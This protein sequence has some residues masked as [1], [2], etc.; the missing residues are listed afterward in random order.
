MPQIFETPTRQELQVKAPI[1]LDDERVLTPGALRFLTNLHRE[2]GLRRLEILK[3]RIK[4]Q[5][6]LDDGKL[7]EFLPETSDIRTQN[8]KISPLPEALQDRRVEITGP[9][10]RKMIINALNSGAKVFMADFEDSTSPTWRN[11]IEGHA[12]LM[13]A[14]R[15][16]ISYQSGDKLYLVN[17][18]PASIHVR[19][20]GWHLEEKH[21]EVDGES[22]SASLV[23]FGLFAY[24]NAEL[25]AAKQ[26]GPF[27]YLPKLE[28]HQE[29]RLWNDVFFFT[30][31]SLEINRGTIKATVLIETIPAV[32]EMD[33]IIFEL[34][35]HMAGLNAGRWDY[36]FSVIKKLKKNSTALTPDRANITMAV[37]FM[38]AYAQLLVKTCHRRGAHA[39]G[40]MS[41]FIPSKDET[42]NKEAFE[43][44]T[45]DKARE[46]SYGYDGTWVAHPKLVSIAQAEFDKVLGKNPHQKNILRPDVNVSAHDLLDIASAG[47][48]ITEKGVRTNINIAIL[49]IESWLRG[50]G[51]VALYNLM[52]DAATAEISRAQ[53]WQWLNHENV[54]LS[55]GRAFDRD[56]YQQLEKEEMDAL[57][58]QF[59]AEDREIQSLSKAEEILNTLVLGESF[60]DFLTTLAYQ[61]ID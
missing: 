20:R 51:A 54:K 5:Q 9:I 48:A 1:L 26:H 37:P 61:H 53:L 28:S 8:W 49:Y 58:K 33:E 14:V 39:M 11:L 55:D 3:A 56:L 47:N 45:D 6:M 50:I 41:A 23:D 43:K 21:I 35:E 46:A 7:P 18:N 12:N 36:I 4:K 29:A 60:E 38:S 27:F 22:M 44:V 57:L 15:G 59:A 17:E 32:F 13:D 31:E 25:L 52:E 24:H 40:G 19:P 10:E 42:V 34:R 16:N 30:E 2:F